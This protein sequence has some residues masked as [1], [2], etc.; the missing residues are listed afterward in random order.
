MQKH[1]PDSA[2]GVTFLWMWFAFVILALATYWLVRWWHRSHPAP[3]P[4]PE[5]SYSQRLKRRMNKRRPV[6]SKLAS[7]SKH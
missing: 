7:P 6:A 1:L 4:E 5:Q 2:I 3:K